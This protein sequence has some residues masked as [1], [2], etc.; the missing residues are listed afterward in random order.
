MKQS[1][2]VKNLWKEPRWRPLRLSLFL[3]VIT[4]FSL[5]FLPDTISIIN[6]PGSKYQ[7]LYFPGLAVLLSLLLAEAHKKGRPEYYAQD[8]RL[9]LWLLLL[10]IVHVFLLIQAWYQFLT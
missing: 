9:L 10:C 7:L 2:S 8:H 3:L 1:F 4:L 5:L 6:Q